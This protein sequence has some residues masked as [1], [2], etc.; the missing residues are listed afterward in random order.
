MY[1]EAREHQSRPVADAAEAARLIVDHE[2][3]DFDALIW[4][5]NGRRLAVVADGHI[6]K[7]WME[8]AVI[9]L[10][11][12]PPIQ[13]ESIT[14]AWCDLNQA[15]DHLRKC[16]TTDFQMGRCS[17]PLDGRGE[18][19]RAKFECGCC[20][21]WFESTLTAQRP[22]D[23]DAGFGICPDCVRGWFKPAD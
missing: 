20:G 21:K 14:F 18:D 2:V 17:L 11:V 3:R 6:D 9:R 5:G 16:E 7:P 23:Q 4:T 22:Y 10:D 1:F 12:N 8:G 13:I 19:V 15:T